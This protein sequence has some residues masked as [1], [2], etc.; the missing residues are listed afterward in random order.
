[1]NKKSINIFS[2]IKTII[3]SILCA[4][5]FCGS[6]IYYAQ[7]DVINN[8]SSKYNQEKLNKYIKDIVITQNENLA[9]EYPKDYRIDMQL[10]YL[11]NVVQEYD[12]AE[13]YYISAVEKSPKWI[14][15]PLYELASFYIQQKKYD[16]AKLILD[17]LPKENNAHL[18]KY[19][20]YLCRKFGNSY[21]NDG[22]YYNA[23]K[24][25]QDAE[26]YWHKLSKPPKKYL[27]EVK[28]RIYHCAISLAD[29]CINNNKISAG[30]HFLEI[31]EKADPKG[32]E[33]N[34]KLAIIYTSK[35]P[36]KSYNYFKKLFDNDPNSIDYKIYHKSIVKIADISRE[37]GNLPKAKLY[38]F[39][40]ENL[41]SNI[42]TNIVHLDDIDFKIVDVSFQEVM[43]RKKIILKFNLE[44]K[45]QY[46][47]DNLHIDVLY[48]L[49]GEV[50]EHFN[51]QLYNSEVKLSSGGK[52]ENRAIIPKHFKNI[53]KK[54][55]PY[56]RVEVYLYKWQNKKTKVFDDYLFKNMPKE[57]KNS[58]NKFDW[59]SFID[60]YFKMATD[61]MSN[62]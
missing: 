15:K 4:C 32:Y 5:I 40:A 54:D 14:Y 52:V 22:N 30:T 6:L 35:N 61:A 9:F 16:S 8:S 23:L 43:K 44:N 28:E 62:K 13:K 33:V 45:S 53:S 29:I 24:Y 46:P 51:A 37:Q 19:Q 7:Y 56:L 36:E 11:Y 10:G 20:S 38:E 39:R 57:K 3:L 31:A 26:Y 60:F 41:L 12:R 47:L 58:K 42:Y 17:N 25:Y 27:K 49:Y 34:Y 2:Y 18:I 55:L 48:S 50:F 21:Y 1:M 59:S